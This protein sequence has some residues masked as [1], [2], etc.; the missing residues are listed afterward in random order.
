MLF[1]LKLRSAAIWKWALSFRSHDWQLADYPVYFREQSPDPTSPF[2]SPR[3][4]FHSN[5]AFI[6]N[7]NLAGH[8][9]S[10]QAALND[11]QREF[12][13]RKSALA[14][15][16]KSLPRPGIKVPI[17]FATQE[18]V[19]AHRDLSVDFIH[20]VLGLEEAWISDESS[21]WDFHTEE[22]NQ[23]YVEKIKQVYGVS[24]D[25]IESGELCE[26]FDRIASQRLAQK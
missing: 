21:L 20:R 5:S 26:I 24:V 19:N 17:K 22:T 25:D 18:Q 16:G 8:G 14:E 23:T 9:D 11:L 13:E 15:E 4:V 2:T 1:D 3:F 7:W 6:V 10:E 12:L